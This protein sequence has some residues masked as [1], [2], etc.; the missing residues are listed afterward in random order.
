MQIQQQQKQQPTTATTITT[1]KATKKHHLCWISIV[2]TQTK[3]WTENKNEQKFCLS[4][5]IRFSSH[6][7]PMEISKNV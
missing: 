3:K 6:I 4:R 1:F 2:K 5:N 7:I